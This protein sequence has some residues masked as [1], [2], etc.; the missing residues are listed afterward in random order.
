MKKRVFFV[1]HAKNILKILRNKKLKIPMDGEKIFK[2]FTQE[3][4]GKKMITDIYVLKIT[5]PPNVVPQKN[6]VIS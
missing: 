2:F 3:R 1:L 4:Y 5:Y 6:G